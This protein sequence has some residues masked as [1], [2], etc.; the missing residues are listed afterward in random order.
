L[1]STNPACLLL[2]LLSAAV[3]CRGSEGG[4]IYAASSPSH[5]FILAINNTR[6]SS[7]QAQTGGGM[8]LKA[9]SKEIGPG[10]VISGHHASQQA[11]GVGWVGAPSLGCVSGAACKSVLSVSCEASISENRAAVAGGGLFL[12]EA[13]DTDLDV[14][15]KC[16]AKVVRN[17]SAAFGS[18]D[19][20]QVSS[21]CKA[22]QV[23]KGGWCDECVAGTL[24]FD[25]DANGCERCPEQAA[26]L[27]GAVVL[28]ESGFWHSTNNSTQIHPC[29][30]PL[31]CAHTPEAISMR[32]PIDW[33][34]SAQTGILGAF[35][36]AARMSM[37]LLHPSRVDRACHL[38][39]LW[40]YIWPR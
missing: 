2:L 24:S 38:A 9:G 11:G 35:V 30:N 5:N 10:T 37:G 7:N 17:N 6:I 29:P 3:S 1:P 20:F 22:G 12:G 39:K 19:I 14:L 13:F 28:P 21:V 16:V 27:G 32:Q 25:P 26:C 23:S 8:F 40:A 36:A 15:G 34:C 18:V 31:A 4:G 33:Q